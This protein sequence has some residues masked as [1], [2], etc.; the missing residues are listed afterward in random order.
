MTAKWGSCLFLI[1]VLAL[2]AG[3]RTTQPV[4]KPPDEREQLRP[5]PPEGRYSTAEY[6]KEAFN[7]TDDGTRRSVDSKAPPGSIGRS[8]MSPTSGMGGMGGR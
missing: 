4:L 7:P 1:G 5:P 2:L 6:P 3:C 8:G